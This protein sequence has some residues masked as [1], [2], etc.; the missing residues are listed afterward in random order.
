MVQIYIEDSAGKPNAISA[1]GGFTLMEVALANGIAGID[2]DCGGAC[3]CA[4]CHVVLDP[5]WV[6]RVPAVKEYEEGL[7][8]SLDNR[9]PNSRLSCQIA[10]D[11]HLDG[12]RVRVPGQD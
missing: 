12:L 10:L 7:L 4:T 5:E 1:R 3:S 11:E 2:A 8:E 6:G 9:E